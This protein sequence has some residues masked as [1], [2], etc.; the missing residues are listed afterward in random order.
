MPLAMKQL[1]LRLSILCLAA[2]MGPTAA[3]ARG[4]GEMTRAEAV[5]LG[6]RIVPPGKDGGGWGAA[7]HQGLTRNGISPTRRNVCSVM[8]VIEQESTY[9]ANPL[10]K[11]LGRMAEKEIAA[12]LSA[13]PL[14][15]AAQ[16]GVT[17]FLATKP[18]PEKSYL[19]L[20]RAAKTERDLDL[21]FRN[22]SFYLF[23]EL[24]STR[25]LN[26]SLLARRVDG[27][28]PVSTLGSMQV[29]IA[30]AIAEVETAKGR[31]LG[32]PAIWKLR[33]ELYTRQG[34]VDYGA[35]MLLGYRAGYDS[36]LYVFADYNAGRYAS[37]NAAFQHMVS[38]LSGHKLALDGDLLLYG[39]AT[40]R[41]EAS[42][43]EKAVRTLSLGLS[44]EDIRADLARGKDY[45][46]RET[47]LYT[48]VAEAYAKETGKPPPYAMIPQIRLE[49][50]KLSK[51]MTTERFARA[52]MARH[53]RCMKTQ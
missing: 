39:G 17:W 42:A 41:R 33:D 37:R 3:L 7:V 50:P 9:T 14:P 29:S 46:F 23:R 32:M 44:D 15:A 52:V 2:L 51:L 24:A 49:S 22:L 36:R 20:I 18:K 43:T 35:R 40:P 12:R 11:G 27:I 48:R 34:G 28:N 47:L 25:L 8:A 30:Y 31:R 4:E 6:K 53:E 10:V 16:H 45:A 19:K 38:E 1:L 13:L 5:A 21:V 26:T